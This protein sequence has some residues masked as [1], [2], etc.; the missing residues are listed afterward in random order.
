MILLCVYRLVKTEKWLITSKVSEGQ[1]N[2]T[3]TVGSFVSGEI[4]ELGDRTV[5]GEACILR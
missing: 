3:S 4:D 5:G 1:E 2:S